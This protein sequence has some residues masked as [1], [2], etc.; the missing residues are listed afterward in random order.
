MGV[1]SNVLFPIAM[2]VGQRTLGQPRPSFLSRRATQYWT[3]RTLWRSLDFVWHVP[4]LKEL[5]LSTGFFPM[6]FCLFLSC[7]RNLIATTKFLVFWFLPCPRW[8]RLSRFFLGF[9]RNRSFHFRLHP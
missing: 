5:K 1:V 8:K 2:W 9:D 4:S 6:F 7:A 3:C